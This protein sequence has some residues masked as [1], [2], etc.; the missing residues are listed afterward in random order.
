MFDLIIRGGQVVTPQGV[1]ECDVAVQG[2][3]IAAV[4]A[5]GTLDGAKRVVDAKGR[6]VMPG[7]ID[8]HVHCAWHLPLPDG[9]A[10]LTDGPEV[11]SRA[12][13]HGG[14]TTMIDFAQWTPG[15]T[16]Q[17]VIEA[18]DKDWVGHCHVDWAYHIMLRGDLPPEVLDQLG[19]A[20]DAGY[21]TVKIF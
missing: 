6:I 16:V 15:N 2:E 14:T 4:A 19:A 11:V 9:T 3:A 1:A 20:I 17:Q 8:P 13:L 21:P 10:M 12:A 18:R 7:G 5:P